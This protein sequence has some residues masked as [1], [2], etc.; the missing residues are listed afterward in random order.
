MRTKGY[1]CF[2]I[3]Y[4]G[5]VGASWILMKRTL[6]SVSRS[7]SNEQ[8]LKGAQGSFLCCGEPDHAVPDVA[9]AGGEGGVD[10]A[11]ELLQ[12]TLGA[13]HHVREFR[14]RQVVLPAGDRFVPVMGRVGAMITTRIL[15]AR[16]AVEL[17]RH[18]LHVRVVVRL[19]PRDVFS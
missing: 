3:D 16:K 10:A 13:V 6:G 12:L 1:A 9:C 18:A 17:N 11:L 14:A 5:N 15:V 4:C 19:R 8:S 7:G 2:H